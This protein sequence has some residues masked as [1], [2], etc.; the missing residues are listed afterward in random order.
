MNPFGPKTF[1]FRPGTVN[2]SSVRWPPAAATR[3]R[4][5]GFTTAGDF[6]TAAG[7]L[8]AVVCLMGRPKW[9]FIM[10][11]SVRQGSYA[12]GSP[13]L[14]VD[15]RARSLDRAAPALGL[16]A[17]E[18]A[19]LGEVEGLRDQPALFELRGKV[20]RARRLDRLR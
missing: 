15:L 2:A 9:Y 6:L 7:L 16:A 1:F 14:V 18:F 20:R 17:E 12:P 4:L 5:G 8:A 11:H 10:T 3:A 19:C 13:Q